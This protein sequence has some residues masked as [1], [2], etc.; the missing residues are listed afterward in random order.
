MPRAMSASLLS[1]FCWYSGVSWAVALGPFCCGSKLKPP[2]C[3]QRPVQSGRVFQ[4]I[5]VPP[6][7]AARIAWNS[8]QELA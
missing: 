6:W 4:V 7:A 3:S 2:V 1:Y 5:L 8:S